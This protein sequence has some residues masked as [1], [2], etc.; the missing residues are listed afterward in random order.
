M[1]YRCHLSPFGHFILPINTFPRKLKVW[2]VPCY[3]FASWT[4][5]KSAQ[6]LQRKT[7]ETFSPMS[8]VL[9]WIH[10]TSTFNYVTCRYWGWWYR[11]P[12]RWP[13][14]TACFFSSQPFLLSTSVL[15]EKLDLLT[16]RANNLRAN[17]QNISWK[18][19]FGELAPT[20]ASRLNVG[21]PL[22]DLQ[23]K[24]VVKVHFE[25]EKSVHVFS[26]TEPILKYCEGSDILTQQ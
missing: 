11:G 2:L 19:S 13:T 25:K 7:G 12:Q 20:C 18:G 3:F 17:L 9:T 26:R 15:A 21:P 8:Q 16:W 4:D 5:H 10:H 6:N 23:L 14:A 1:W 22:L 24:Q